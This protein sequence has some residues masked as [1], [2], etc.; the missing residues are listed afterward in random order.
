QSALARSLLSLVT[1]QAEFVTGD[2]MKAVRVAPEIDDEAEAVVSEA[3]TRAAEDLHMGNQTVGDIIGLSPAFVSQ[4]R[5][6]NK[7]LVQ[8]KKPWQLALLLVRVYRSLFPLAG[9]DIESMR[10]WLGNENLEL[11]GAVPLQL[12][13]TPQGLVAVLDYL[14]G[15]RA[16]I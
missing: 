10:D 4:M 13:T 9:G 1:Y 12:L 15:Y 5:H 8:G 2:V 3:V 6:G 16:R 7:R 11:D 14:D